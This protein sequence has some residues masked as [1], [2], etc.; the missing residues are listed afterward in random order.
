M[1]DIRSI[2]CLRANVT[3]D[4]VIRAFAAAG[5]AS[6][7]WRLRY[8]PLQRMAQAYLPYRL[9][10]IHYPMGGARRTRL[11]AT[12]A[13]NGSLDLFEFAAPPRQEDLLTLSTRN[14]PVAVLTEAQSEELLREKVLRVIFQQ[15]F[16]KLRA[17]QLQVER[18]P[19][20]IYLPYWLGL[21]GS[22]ETLHCRVL[23]AVRR[24]VEG[25]KVSALFEDWLAA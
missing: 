18:L 3:R 19:D 15:G 10:R 9:Y 5:P 12:D 16:F 17:M 20:E 22:G 25:A 2:R 24:R 8:G 13:V 1:S 21:Y 7:Y 4:Q 23:D 11:F 6:W 14:A